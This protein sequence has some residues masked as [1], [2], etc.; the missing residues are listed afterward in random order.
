MLWV[1]LL[2]ADM[3]LQLAERALN[4]PATLVVADGPRNRPFVNSLSAKARD[5]GIRPGMPVAAAKALCADLLV[6]DRNPSKESEALHGIACWAAQFTPSIAFQQDRGLLLEVSTTLTLH[7]GLPALLARLKTGLSELG[8]RAAAG[9]APTPDAAWLFA[10]ARHQ[11]MM[12]RTCT[13]LSDLASKVADLPLT[14]FEWPEK[15]L[16]TLST[17]GLNRVTDIQRLPREGITARFGAHV[18]LDVDRAIGDAPHPFPFFSPPETFARSLEFGFELKETD[19]LL[20]PIKRL[21]AE[22]EGFLRARGAGVQA[23]KLDVMHFR[24]GVSTLEVGSGQPQCEQNYLLGLMKERLARF[25]L[26]SPAL[27]I[28][29]IADRFFAFQAK[30]ASWLPAPKET[31]IGWAQLED[32]LTSRLGHAAVF[33]LAVRDDHRPELSW[34][35]VPLT[36]PYKPE[37]VPVSLAPRPLFLLAHPRGLLSQDGAPLSHGRLELLAGP[38]RIEAGWWDGRE[39]SRDYFV[40]RNPHGETLWIY[41]EHRDLQRW[42]LHGIFA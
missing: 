15:E 33:R 24:G 21:L 4:Y 7:R 38:E 3:P 32:K 10:K 1:A 27:G 25:D 14:L 16:Q 20:F 39:Q 26:P 5:E 34:R 12:I 35:Q 9:V 2:L 40:A 36:E 42:Y 28:R 8:Y 31:S 37:R 23:F 30:S 19:P 17:L 6:F 41:R 29:L 13:S 22:L 11:G 18:L